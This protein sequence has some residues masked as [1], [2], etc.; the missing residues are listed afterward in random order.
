[1]YPKLKI[2]KSSGVIGLGFFVSYL[3]GVAAGTAVGN[4][5]L[6]FDWIL[7]VLECKDKEPILAAITVYEKGSMNHG[8]TQ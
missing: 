6:L 3:A 4:L 7:N 1:M 2:V 8:S 5:G